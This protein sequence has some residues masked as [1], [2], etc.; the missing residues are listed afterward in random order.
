MSV[1]KN[2]FLLVGLSFIIRLISTFFFHDSHIDN[3]WGILL[4]NLVKYKTYSFYF[5][6][7]TLLPSALMPP[8]Y[9]YFLYF[10]KILT[11]E[12]I[13]FLYTLMFF[14]IIFSTISVYI[15]YK[16]NEKLFS[17][18]TTFVPL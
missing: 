12:K 1:K 10:I 3:E 4:N 17:N 16:I 5:Y 9:A 15:F 2:I 11:F 7:D 6:E 8:L 14:Q 18:K 13:N